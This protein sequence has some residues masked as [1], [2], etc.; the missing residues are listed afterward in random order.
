MFVVVAVDCVFA[1]LTR[2]VSIFVARAASY[3]VVKIVVSIRATMETQKYI[4][5]ELRKTNVRSAAKKV[6]ANVRVVSCI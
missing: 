5:E 6:A 2:V 4:E 3:V 1:V